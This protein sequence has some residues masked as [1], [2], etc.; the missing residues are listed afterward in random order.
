MTRRAPRRPEESIEKLEGLLRYHDLLLRD[1]VRNAAFT[2]ALRAR[3]RPGGRVLDVGT[4]SGLWA[5]VAAK[6]GASRVVAVEREPLL[7]PIIEGL[8]AEN[9]VGARVELISGDFRGLRL[10][11]EFDVVV[12]ETVGN[13]LFDEDLVRVMAGARARFLVEGGAMIPETVVFRAAPAVRR[14]TFPAPRSLPLQASSFGELVRQVPRA[15]H[16]AELTCLAPPAELARVDLARCAAGGTNVGRVDASWPLRDLRKVDGIA[17]WLRLGL[18]PGVWLESRACD[19]WH[20]TLFPVGPF[21]ARRGT[22]HFSLETRVSPMA[23]RVI[24]DGAEGREEADHS[25][26]FAY[27]AVRAAARRRRTMDRR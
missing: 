7:R 1:R 3:L 22:L 23:W 5:I 4:G 20:S 6:L 2:R 21:R 24:V 9:G 16:R 27:G 19:A 17:V 25:A 11:R 10:A 18:S 15:A 8:I 13:L 26:A 14:S 12:S